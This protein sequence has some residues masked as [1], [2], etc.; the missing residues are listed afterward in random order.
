MLN[1]KNYLNGAPSNRNAH[2]RILAITFTNKATAEMKSRIIKQLEALTHVPESDDPRD[3]AEYAA[4]LMAD[5][6]CRRDELQHVALRALRSLLND[7]GQFNVSTIDAF[8]PDHTA[9]LCPRDRPPGRLPARAGGVYGN[10]A[11]RG[12]DV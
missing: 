5:F 8:F 12:H 11:G 2:R 4:K 7:Y 1:H 3:D 10:R 6:G 9:Q